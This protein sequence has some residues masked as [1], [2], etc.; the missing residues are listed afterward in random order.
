[1]K[2][3]KIEELTKKHTDKDGKF[4]NEE[5]TKELNDLTNKE[6]KK[7]VSKDVEKMTSANLKT[8]F[9]EFGVSNKDELKTK[10]EQKAKVENEEKEKGANMSNENIEKIVADAV[11]KAKAEA[12]AESDALQQKQK[13]ESEI[14][15]LLID[16]GVKKDY[17][18]KALK[19]VE[20][21]E[22]F[23]LT[24]TDAIVKLVNEELNM[25]KEDYAVNGSG[26]KEDVVDYGSDTFAD[27]IVDAME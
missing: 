19:V 9:E 6:I 10:L 15:K 27:A 16:N 5:F 11:E 8:M 18:D 13:K 20:I 26:A 22:D 12:K 14:K 7:V 4:N 25:F 24:D 2:Q 23:D 1:M 21:D 17:A 3:E